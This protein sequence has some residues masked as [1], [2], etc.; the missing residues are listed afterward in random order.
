MALKRKYSEQ[1]RFDAKM[2]FRR[3]FTLPEI[4]AETRIPERT[5][6]R[7]REEG[8]WDGEIPATTVEEQI[9]RR[10]CFLLDKPDKGDGDRAELGMLIGQ[11]GDLSVKLAQARKL[12]RQ[13]TPQEGDGDKHQRNSKGKKMKN[14]ISAITPEMLDRA[15]DLIFRGVK[16]G[17]DDREPSIFEIVS[18]GREPKQAP[19][20][21][22][23]YLAT[24]YANKHQRNRFILKSRQIGATYYFAW[25][26]LEDAIRTGDNQIFLSASRDQADVFRAYIVMFA[27]LCLGLELTGSPI[28]LNKGDKPWAELRFVSTNASTAQSYHGHL[29]LDEVF[30][31]RDFKK[32]WKVASGM[33][34]HKKWRRTLFSTP[35]A[36]SHEA[37]AKWSGED[38]NRGRAPR[39]QQVFDISWEALNKGVLGPD[40]IWR[41][42][43]TVEDAERQGCD[44][45]DIEE[46]RT[47][48]SRDDFDNLFM[49][50]FID[51]AQSAFPLD[52]LLRCT[53]DPASWK[54]YRADK[55]R[56]LGNHPL[57]L[58][59]DPAST[60]D[61]ASLAYCEVP[62]RPIDKWRVLKRDRWV[63]QS[64]DFQANRIKDA[65]L[66]FNVVF[67]GIDA[68]GMGWGVSELVKAFYPMMTPFAY[69][70]QVKTE[71]VMKGV[72][73]MESGRLEF[74]AGDRE[75]LQAFLSIR[76]TMTGGGGQS[77]YQAPRKDGQ[78][79]DAAWSVLHALQFEKLDASG[80]N[81]ATVSR[82]N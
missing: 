17:G 72:M 58:G 6:F 59:Y 52:L 35:S 8:K 53:V 64:L 31:I 23:E 74:D 82:L 22:W 21:V 40:K 30:W 60:G 54:H 4:Q 65:T 9:A 81:E 7:W 70:P 46:L 51:D 47:E 25:E 44:L 62:L 45:F 57:S 77:T 50:K 13:G 75:L 38:F 80:A 19:G 48:Y 10:V 29:Y 24:W 1:D 20:G 66:R 18:G 43:V 11:L 26:A 71:L 79:A 14:D 68:T 78:H 28:L 36:M 27:K 63:K 16:P 67:L 32:M 69:S 42:I 76:K 39:Y 5:L 33:A 15:R 73:T 37:Y 2:L 3:G 61:S 12:D 55:P 56:P 34:A 49:C 41:H